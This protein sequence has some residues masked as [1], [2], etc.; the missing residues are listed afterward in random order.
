M[1]F[2]G[3]RNA[4][5]LST[6]AFT[7]PVNLPEYTKTHDSRNTYTN[8]RWFVSYGP[9][10]F[11]IMARIEK[12]CEMGQNVLIQHPRLFP[13]SCPSIGLKSKSFARFSWS[14]IGANCLRPKSDATIDRSTGGCFLT[15]CQQ[16]M[17][18]Q[19]NHPILSKAV[20]YNGRG[21]Y[22]VI[23]FVEREVRPPAVGEVRIR[24]KAAAVNPTDI[25]LRNGYGGDITT[26]AV[27]GMDL[28]GVIES[29]GEGVTRLKVGQEVMAAVMPRRPEGGAQA[30]YVV[31]PAASAVPLPKDSTIAEAST[32]PMNGL[33][34]L[35]ALELMGLTKGQNLAV[36][37][38]AGLLA[39]YVIVL[40]KKQG[41]TVIADAKTAEID[42]V[43]QH[44]A[45]V[46]VERSEDFAGAVRREMPD[47]VDALLDTALLAEKSFA[48]IRDGG[49]YIPLRGWGDKPTERGINIK[50]VFVYEVLERTD[51]MELLKDLVEAGKIKLRVAGEYAPE[52]TADAQR[53]LEAGGLR[54]RPVILF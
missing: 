28:A 32:L 2:P 5:E 26:A 31:I 36:S 41:L 7:T 44:G 38:G 12:Q 24:V 49:V 1:I 43:K 20:T 19:S 3:T 52:K 48:A 17:P 29:V 13:S 42:L 11:G 34:A 51:W 27:P 40:A 35:R 46:V 21:S 14:R 6:R 47:G 22:D 15:E 4:R 39:Y 30:Q 53:A 37:G 9:R 18:D 54:G 50:P 8:F 16:I 33:T 10:P 23:E 45:D 25:L